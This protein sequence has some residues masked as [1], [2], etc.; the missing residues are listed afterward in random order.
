M[1]K[2]RQSESGR[3]E[4]ASDRYSRGCDPADVSRREFLIRCCQG[5]SAAFVPASFSGRVLPFAYSSESP[6][7]P[8]LGSDFHLHPHY[9]AKLPLE[10]TLF[11]TQAGLDDFV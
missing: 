8:S 7:L 6:K 5:A 2:G 3:E 9:R 1:S 10:A 4:A 11:K